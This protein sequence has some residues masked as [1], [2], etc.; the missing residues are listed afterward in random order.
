MDLRF[1]RVE[2]LVMGA[3]LN[4]I[5]NKTAFERADLK[6]LAICTLNHLGIFS[7]TAYGLDIEIV[8]FSKIDGGVEVFARAEKNGKA[9][10]FGDGSVEIERFR[11]FNPPICVDDPNG[12]IAQTYTDKYTGKI[13]V[14]KLLESPVRAIRE[15]IAHNICLVGIPG[16]NPIKNKVGSTVNTYYP[17]AHTETSSVDGAIQVG[18]MPYNGDWTT[19]QASTGSNCYADPSGALAP[20]RI[21][22]G[23]VTDKFDLIYRFFALFNTANLTSSANISSAVL[24]IYLNS[25]YQSSAGWATTWNVYSSSPA[26]NT[27]LVAND[28]DNV[29]ATEFSTTKSFA[30]MST[31]AYN[32]FTLNAAGRAAIA[33]TGVSK[34]SIR[35]TSYDVPNSAPPWGYGASEGL[36]VYCADQSGTAY[37]PKLVVTFTITALPTGNFF[38]F[39]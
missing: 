12:D 11:I 28:F 32:D 13:I 34:F 19:M 22:C 10:G 20:L 36:N 6:A 17:D 39:M 15:V 30:S 38:W 33:K 4:I 14:R 18:G 16:S 5:K 24:S 1:S 37:D 7:D 3:I 35:E 23:T 2:G 25:K 21:N 26:S 31:T 8:G 9:I 29:G 27:N